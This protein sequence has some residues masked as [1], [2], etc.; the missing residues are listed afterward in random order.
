MVE[1]SVSALTVAGLHVGCRVLC[2][3][4]RLLEKNINQEMQ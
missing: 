1:I 2:P 3:V 4:E